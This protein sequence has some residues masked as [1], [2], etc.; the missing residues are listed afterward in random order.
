MK[1]F[2]LMAFGLLMVVLAPGGCP[3]PPG[4]G[5]L[6]D[7]AQPPATS[8]EDE[9]PAASE[10]VPAV[11]DEGGDEAESPP[12]E[13][14]DDPNAVLPRLPAELPDGDD[15]NQGGPA[16]APDQN[17]DGQQPG[18]ASG[19][20]DPGT[21]E[22]PDS[23][24]RSGDVPG[25]AVD[26]VAEQLFALAGALG[27]C[28]A[29]TDDRLTLG[30]NQVGEFGECPVVR[31]ASDLLWSLIA[32]DFAAGCA[33][34]ITADQVFTGNLAFLMARASCWA[35]AEYCD[36]SMAGK[37]VSGRIDAF[38]YKHPGEV[39]LE[40]SCSVATSHVGESG[41]TIG[42]VFNQAGDFAFTSANLAVGSGTQLY[43]LALAGLSVDPVANRNFVPQAG[44]V[45]FEIPN[46]QPPPATLA[47][48][49]T[50]TAR[51]PLDGTV[52][53]SV[54]GADPVEHRIP[55]I[56]P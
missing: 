49:V 22:G 13:L 41:G 48:V 45:S 33:S 56:G 30:P 35:Q 54:N 23:G 2:R 8:A 39:R 16:A 3:P 36:F 29:L 38:L 1:R 28:S 20:Q 31:F 19:G 42:M 7:H 34:E 21:G 25:E 4:G 17:A 52:L 27:T 5:E 55:G 12:A 9:G 44:T 40:G 47:I 10:A 26:Q 37:A 32:I 6:G 51:S 50:F 18:G 53:V 46:D 15:P 11:E 14:E 24:G 43:H